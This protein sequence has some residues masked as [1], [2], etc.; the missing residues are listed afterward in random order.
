M[1]LDDR[2]RALLDD[3]SFAVLATLNAD[4][5]PQT[6]VIWAARDG[7]AVLFTTHT[8]RRKARNLQRDPRAS[9]TIFAAAD[10]YRTANISGTVELLADPDRALSVELT[11]R[12]LGEDPPQDPPG[13]Q[14]LIGRLTPE[15]VG[16]FA[17]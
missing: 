9:L 4:G 5:S 3:R 2:A 6:S 12:Y 8:K 16:G 11:R 14:R 15:H 17:R 10:P 1:V 13:S 7:D